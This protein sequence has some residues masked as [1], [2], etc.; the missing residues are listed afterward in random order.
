[1][2]FSIIL[3]TYN[4][5]KFISKAIESVLKQIHQEWELI[6]IDDGS[7]DNTN[8]II[9]KYTSKDDRVRYIF[10]ENNRRSYI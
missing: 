7:T 1:M 8:K 9:K 10:Q 4:R 3:P 5:E 6:I 2:N